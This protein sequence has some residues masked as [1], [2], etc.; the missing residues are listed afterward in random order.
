MFDDCLNIIQE[1]KLPFSLATAWIVTNSASWC[2][3]LLLTDPRIT[4]NDYLFHN[5]NPLAPPPTTIDIISDINTSE[6][7]VK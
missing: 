5:N 7:C 6:A 4:D 3:Q 2:I 1:I